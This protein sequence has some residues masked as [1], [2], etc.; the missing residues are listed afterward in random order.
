MSN[1]QLHMVVLKSIRGSLTWSTSVITSPTSR[2]SL[3][4]A[5]VRECES[6]GGVGG[7]RKKGSR[8][9]IMYKCNV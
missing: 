3:S 1:M 9:N 2:L 8:M 7:G 5:S 6:L 4:A